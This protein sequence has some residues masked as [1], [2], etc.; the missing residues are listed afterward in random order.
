MY[1]KL[2]LNY[3]EHGNYVTNTCLLTVENSL[4][5]VYL[6]LMVIHA[7]M[8]II[9]CTPNYIHLVC[10]L[11]H[12]AWNATE[13]HYLFAIHLRIIHYFDDLKLIFHPQIS[14]SF[15]QGCPQGVFGDDC[16]ENCSLHCKIPMECDRVTG[17]CFN[18]CQ[19]GW[20]DPTCNTSIS[21]F[22]LFCF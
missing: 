6:Y 19:S 8:T 2:K 9:A 16:M 21:E 12:F 3:C 20:G 1:A 22:L 4:L 10:L 15:L 18:G 14:I 5:S 17:R 11:Y 13:S 7:Q